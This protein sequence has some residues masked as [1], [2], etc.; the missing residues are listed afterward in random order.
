[1]RKSRVLSFLQR[2][3]EAEKEQEQEI[4]KMA[5]EF[6][7]ERVSCISRFRRDLVSVINITVLKMFI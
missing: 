4:R 6:R 5:S 1:M 2:A 3:S 7:A